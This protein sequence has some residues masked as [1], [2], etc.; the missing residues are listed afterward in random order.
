[1][2]SEVRVLEAPELRAESESGRHFIVG[3]L[4]PYNVEANVSGRFLETI[5]PGCFRKSIG[6]SARRLPLMVSHRHDE[7]PVG[8]AVEWDDRD[9][10]LYGRWEVADTAQAREVFGL[11]NDEHLS[12]LSVGFMPVKSDWDFREPPD[13]DRVARR[14][15][16]MLEASLTPVP[17]WADAQVLLTRTSEGRVKTTPRADLYREWWRTVKR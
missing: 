11:V 12:G 2:S 5:I 15:A 3:R 6:E 10:G 8:S 4:V 17:T 9:D 16:R 13:M 1:M 14:E 7:L